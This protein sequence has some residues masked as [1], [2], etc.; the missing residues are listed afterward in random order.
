MI[1]GKGDVMLKIVTF[2]IVG[3]ILMT[4]DMYRILQRIPST[5]IMKPKVGLFFTH[6]TTSSDTEFEEFH[7]FPLLAVI[8][9]CVNLYYYIRKIKTV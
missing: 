5:I 8:I 2:N 9:I 3:F 4:A 6:Y 7:F 1:F